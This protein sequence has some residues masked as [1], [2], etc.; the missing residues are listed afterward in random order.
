MIKNLR[1]DFFQ[2]FSL[3]LIWVTLLM[4]LFL[5]D[6]SIQISYLWNIIGIA[7]VF[8][9]MFG[10]LYK[11]LWDYLTLK[12]IMNILISSILNMIGGLTVVALFSLKMFEQIINWTLGILILT[13]ILHTIAF[14]FVASLDAKKNAEALNKMMKEDQVS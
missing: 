3:S 11:V 6:G 2:V 10:V 9:L 4:T 8:G 13:I 7:A 1:S 12:P 5:S 14:Y